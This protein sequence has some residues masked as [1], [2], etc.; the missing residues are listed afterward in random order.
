MRQYQGQQTFHSF[1]KSEEETVARD[2]VAPGWQGDLALDE[3][4]I[5][6]RAIHFQS[7]PRIGLRYAFDAPRSDIVDF[8]Y[9]EVGMRTT[10]GEDEWG[11]VWSKLDGRIESSWGQVIAHPLESWGDFE[12]PDP[13]DQARF[14]GVSQLD[15]YPTKYK[16]GSFPFPLVNRL[17]FLRGTKN[18]MME[19]YRN[20]TELRGL[21]EKVLDFARGVVKAYGEIGLDGVWFGD[22]LASQK[23]LLFSLRIWREFIRPWYEELFRCA[24][25]AGLDVI[26]HTCGQTRLILEDL[27]EIGADALNLNQ[28]ELL[29]IDWMRER[30]GGKASLFCPVDTQLIGFI[31]PEEVRERAVTMV[32]SLAREDGG[33]IALCDEGGNH[34]TVPGS[35]LVAMGEAFEAFRWKRMRVS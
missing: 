16:A 34:S 18:L 27:A 31:S 1:G 32:N 25:S 6:S 2:P 4:E 26:F 8:R 7:P 23:S 5:V 14:A 17:M 9:S 21:A 15:Q 12:A 28:P 30:L 33:F 13:L 24:H 19:F 22:D 29:G 20:P 10:T 11:C 3:R 35:N